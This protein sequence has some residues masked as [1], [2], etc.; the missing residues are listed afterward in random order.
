M[1]PEWGDKQTIHWDDFSASNIYK[2]LIETPEDVKRVRYIFRGMSETDCQKSLQAQQHVLNLAKAY[3][4]P[5][6]CYYGFGLAMPMFM[7]GAQN[8]VYFAMDEPQAFDELAQVIHEVD[9]RR[10]ELAKRAGVDILKRFG[11]YEMVNLYN[12]ETFESV[13]VPRLKKEVEYAHELQLL[14][15]YRVVTGMEPL[16][17]KIASIGFDCIEGGEPYL[18]RCSLEMWHEAFTGKACSWTG[19]STPALLGGND[20]DTV[21]REV[22]HAVEIF[23]KKGFILGVTNSIRNHFP[24]ENTLA[25]VDEW[26]K[27]R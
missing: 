10:L 4:I 16:L 23:G 1:T 9:L 22:R 6:H 5:V 8:V 17:D 21:R 19:I 15:Y 2:P 20:P 18:S 7:M 14:I 13:V 27:M 25:M 11:G 12:P 3:N 26:K 24:W